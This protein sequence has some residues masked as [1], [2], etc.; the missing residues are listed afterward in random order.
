MIRADAD[1]VSFNGSGTGTF[2]MNTTGDLNITGVFKSNSSSSGDYVRMYAGSGT[3]KWDIYGNGQYLR[4]SDND[5]VGSVRVDTRFGVGTAASNANITSYISATGAIPTTALI[6]T[7][8]DNHAMNLWN[9]SNSATY[10]GLML[11]TRTSGASGWLIANE[12][13]STYAGDLIF[14]GRSSGSASS[15]RLRIKS[16]GEMGLGTATPPTGTF[17]IHLTETPELNL[18]S[19]QH[20]QGNHCKLNFG[21][22]QSASV[23]GNTGARIEMNIPNAG[24]AMSGELK[25]H[26]NSGDNL[27]EKV[28]IPAATWGLLVTNLPSTG[29]TGGYQT[30]GVSLRYD[31]DST[32]VRTNSAAVTM[33]RK[34]NAGRALDFYSGTS[35]AGGIYVNGA[36][37]VQFQNSDYRLKTDVNSIT[38]GIDKVKQLN[39]VYYK[40]KDTGDTVNTQNGFIAH[41][42][43]SV[44]PTLV[45]GEKDATI[46][47]KG[48]GYQGLNYTGFTPTAI[49]AI[50]EL[51]AKVET[52]EAKVAALEGS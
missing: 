23:S 39:P 5:S 46:D 50:K 24:G 40:W 45:F 34:G 15:E 9:G 22:G 13:Q 18:F 33:T 21:V 37:S 2:E 11:E 32:F 44:I 26:T 51:I 20:S 36:N 25:F 31:G 42:V 29:A 52:L 6:Q 28:R 7:N 3:G 47:E 1:K 41:E 48:Q 49:A 14:R 4:I 35:F 38:D 8:N 10:C 16:T 43:Q 12:W 27:V 19:T 30:E 17:T